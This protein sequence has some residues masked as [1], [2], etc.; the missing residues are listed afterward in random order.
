MALSIDS[1]RGNFGI[2]FVL[3]LFYKKNE[4]SFVC[5]KEKMKNPGHKRPGFFAKHNYRKEG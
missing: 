1:T 2:R 5:V 3:L 4:K